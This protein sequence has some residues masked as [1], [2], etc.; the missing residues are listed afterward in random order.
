M[1]QVIGDILHDV[2]DAVEEY[3]HPILVVVRDWSTVSWVCLGSIS[4]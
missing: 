2:V 4:R 3:D 1:P